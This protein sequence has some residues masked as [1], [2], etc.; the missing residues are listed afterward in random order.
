MMNSSLEVKRTIKA[1]IEKV[2]QAW[3]DQEA[4]KKWYS[5]EQMSVG[6]AEVDLRSGGAYRIVMDGPDGQH[7]VGGTYIEVQKPSKL[8]FS[9][10]W[11][12][13][14]TSDSKVTVELAEVDSNTTEVTLRHED[15]AGDK[16]VQMHTQGWDSTLRNLEAYIG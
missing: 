4:V 2:W 13:S 11:E 10:K 6:T 14:D 9:W 1:P 7:V 15:L 12:G 5:P 3:T 16:D 8:V